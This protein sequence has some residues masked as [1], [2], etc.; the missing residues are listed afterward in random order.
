M[1]ATFPPLP[2]C[3]TGWPA[4]ALLLCDQLALIG[5]HCE[6]LAMVDVLALTLTA[7]VRDLFLS[8][9]RYT[10]ILHGNTQWCLHTQGIATHGR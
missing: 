9:L 7:Q 4:F 1:T 2:P 10:G 5:W 3:Q 6:R 8:S